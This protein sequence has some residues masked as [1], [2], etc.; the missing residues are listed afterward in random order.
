MKRHYPT[1]TGIWVA[2]VSI[3]IKSPYFGAIEITNLHSANKWIFE[4]ESKRGAKILGYD[5]ATPPRGPL[6]AEMIRAVLHSDWLPEDCASEAT[7]TRTELEILC[8][9]PGG[10]DPFERIGVEVAKLDWAASATTYQW[11]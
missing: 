3:E 5:L 7:S 11:D 2:L 4:T 1:A 8:F 10:E 9:Q 6:P